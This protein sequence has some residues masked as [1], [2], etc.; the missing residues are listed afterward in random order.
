MA[1]RTFSVKAVWDEEAGVY[2]SESDIIGFHIEAGTLD[3]FEELMMELGPEL[4]VAN[5][6]SAAERAA[7]SYEELMPA[8]IW[9][10]PDPAV[11]A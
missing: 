4:I 9:Q 8:I 7:K 2:V 3:E 6:M 1:K 11:A 10:R 5:H